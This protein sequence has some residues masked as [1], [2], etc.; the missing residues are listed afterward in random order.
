MFPSPLSLELYGAPMSAVRTPWHVYF[1]I[2]LRENAPPDIQVKFE[3]T[4]TTGPQRG[5]LL[6]LRRGDAGARDGEARA[7]LGLWPLLRTDTLVEYKSL[8]WPLH[9]GDLARLQGSGPHGRI[10]KRDVESALKGGGAQRTPA[11]PVQSTAITMSPAT[12]AA[13][14]AMPDDKVLALYDQGSYEVV[15]HDGMRRVIA[16]SVP[17]VVRWANRNSAEAPRSSN[18]C[19]GSWSSTYVPLTSMRAPTRSRN[20]MPCTHAGSPAPSTS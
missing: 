20:W 12:A 7:F 16:H 11:A 13:I 1:A 6:L 4:L 18:G 2:F 3:I 14:Q 19:A 10:I 17:N 8:A 9:K 5:D 15:P